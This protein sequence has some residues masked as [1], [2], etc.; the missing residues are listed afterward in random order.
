MTDSL[1][2]FVFTDFLKSYQYCKTHIVPVPFILRPWR[3]HENNGSWIYILAAIYTSSARKNAEIK[4]SRVLVF[5]HN[6]IL[7]LTL[8]IYVR[9]RILSFL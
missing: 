5:F 6:S 2:N 4:G 3:I 7:L 8:L 9:E 1:T